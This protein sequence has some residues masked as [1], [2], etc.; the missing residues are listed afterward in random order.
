[1]K[2]TIKFGV[3]GTSAVTKLVH[4]PGL[5]SH[6][7]AKITAICGRNQERAQEVAKEYDIPKVYS[8]YREMIEKAGIDAVVIVT[9]NNL[10]YPMI[11]DALEAKLHVLCE[12]P[13]ALDLKQ[14]K[15]VCEKADAAGVKHM[16]FF[17]LRWDPNYRYFKELVDAGY[18]GRLFNCYL[19]WIMGENLKRDQYHWRSD[20]A[21]NKGAL[22]GSCSPI[23]DLAHLF[24]GDIDK[25]SASLSTFMPL[26]PPQGQ[27]YEPADDSAALSV[28]FKNGAHGTLYGSKVVHL[29]RYHLSI[30]ASGEKGILESDAWNLI[31]EKKPEMRG[32]QTSEKEV[33][34]LEVPN[35]Y[36]EGVDRTKSQFERFLELFTKQSSGERLFVDSI[37][38]DKMVSPNFYDCLKVQRVIHA[39]EEADKTGKWVSV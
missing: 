33:S 36:W 12:K 39:A 4:L 22:W 29:G 21:S 30:R 8:D 2:T 20:K 34:K 1:M 13:L 18:V 31:G 11:M 19:H 6:P 15:E 27:T 16:A 17:N 26:P 3:I 28:R 32:A 14:A 35:R 25:V 38:N 7:N 37:Y 5:Q 24:F 9:P 23:I 10:H